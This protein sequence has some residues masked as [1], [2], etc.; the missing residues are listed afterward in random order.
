[1]PLDIG[2]APS[3]TS[4]DDKSATCMLTMSSSVRV[5]ASVWAGL[6]GWLGAEFRWVR[7]RSVSGA[8]TV[9]G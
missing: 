5:A 7:H 8:A 2:Q 6:S 3:T 4:M 9:P 1:M